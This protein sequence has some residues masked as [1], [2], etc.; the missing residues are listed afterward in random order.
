MV[1]IQNKK[2]F[3]PTLFGLYLGWL[4]IFLMVNTSSFSKDWLTIWTPESNSPHTITRSS[5]SARVL[6]GLPVQKG[7]ALSLAPWQKS[8]SDSVVTK[9]S[10]LHKIQ[11]HWE[12]C[13]SMS[14]ARGRCVCLYRCGYSE[15]LPPAHTGHQGSQLWGLQ[16]KISYWQMLLF[17]CPKLC[18][19]PESRVTPQRCLP[20]NPLVLREHAHGWCWDVT[21]VSF[22]STRYAEGPISLFVPFFD[23]FVAGCCFPDALAINLEKILIKFT[24]LCISNK[25][26]HIP[27]QV[28]FW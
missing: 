7:L 8:I 21:C 12:V 5:G 6:I 11:A 10:P 13:S 1:S 28:H 2:L 9:N 19:W 17:C 18:H 25:H 26:R 24:I 27:A 3:S 4:V 20:L 23:S 15:L 22:M 16:L 14:P